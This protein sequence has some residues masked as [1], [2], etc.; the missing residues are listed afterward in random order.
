MAIILLTMFMFEK[1]KHCIF[2]VP[3]FL[4]VYIFLGHQIGLKLVFF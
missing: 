4:Y 1:E 3:C 2:K